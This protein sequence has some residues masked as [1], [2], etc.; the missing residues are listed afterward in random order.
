MEFAA[1]MRKNIRGKEESDM[2]WQENLQNE[3]GLE[4]LLAEPSEK[5]IVDMAQIKG[6]IMVLGAGG[7][8]GPS[9]CR[10]IRNASKAAGISRDIFA[11]SR[12]SDPKA[13][14]MLKETGV[15]VIPCDL[16]DPHGLASLPDANHIIYMAGRK[17]G[18]GEDAPMTW[19]MNA[20]VPSFVSQRFAGANMV[21]FSSGNIYPPVRLAEGVG[22]CTE[23][24]PAGPLGEYAM[25][26]LARERIFAYAAMA[27]GLKV[28]LFRLNYAVDLRYGVLF[29]IAEKVKN[30]R[31][32]SLS[33]PYFNC[34]WQGD[35]NE[36]AVRSLL[37]T[38]SP[39]RILNVTGPETVSVRTA[40]ERF[41]E[42][43]GIT[44]IFCD[45]P[46][47]TALLNNAGQAMKLFG[48][49]RFSIDELIEMQAAWILNGGKGLGKPTHFEVRD[50]V[51]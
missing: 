2:Q 24:T 6:S 20:A 35:A 14:S 4:A 37:H 40:A 10:L 17:F 27:K 15:H 7:K 45:E 47:E 38:S 42:F 12:F 23:E 51:Y 13:A 22:G 1:K 39:A 5:L 19:A 29:D 30:G 16:L 34:I 46:G 32:V 3:A 9:L 36:A 25:S 18:T 31:P 44:P 48:Y 8:M 28:L 43:F 41:G 26:C 21:V 49:P 50:G 11:V 33:V